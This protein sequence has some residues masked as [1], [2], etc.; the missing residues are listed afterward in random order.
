MGTPPTGS[1]VC[2]HCKVHNASHIRTV[3]LLLALHRQ[4]Y[5][6]NNLSYSQ[7]ITNYKVTH[8]S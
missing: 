3:G 8:I 4:T 6:T 7:R 5:H 1:G 2:F